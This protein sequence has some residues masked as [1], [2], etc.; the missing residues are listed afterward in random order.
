MAKELCRG[1]LTYAK[2]VLDGAMWDQ[3]MTMSA[4]YCGLKTGVVLIGVLT[5]RHLLT[6]SD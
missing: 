4:W 6:G 5:F 3:L 1:E 2:S